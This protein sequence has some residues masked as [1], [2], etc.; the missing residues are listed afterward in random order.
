M[1]R[2]TPVE[3][4]KICAACGRPFSWRKRWVRCWEEVKY[5]SQRCRRSAPRRGTRQQG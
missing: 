1:T 4:S 2:H 5:C 3:R